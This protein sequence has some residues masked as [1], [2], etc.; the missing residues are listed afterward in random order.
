MIDKRTIFEIQQLNE[1]GKSQREIAQILSLSRMTVK[2]YILDSDLPSQSRKKRQ[3]KLEPYY[4]KINQF[5]QDDPKVSSTVIFQH[6]KELGYEGKLTILTDYIREKRGQ[7]K[8]KQAFI[9]F[10]S[11][12][13][14]QFQIDWGEFGSLSYGNTKRKLYAMLVTECHSRMLYV[15]FTHSQ[16]QSA[17]H[18]CLWHAFNYFGGTTRQII[19]DNMLT[20]VIERS[21]KIIRYNDAFLEFLR[22]FKISPAACTPRAPYEKGKVERSVG[23]VKRNFWPLR[24]FTDLAD[25]QTQALEWLEKIANVRTHQ[26]TGEVPLNR[27]QK[28]KLRPLPEVDFD[29]RETRDLLVH[30]DFS[31][32]FDCNTYTVHPW[33]IGKHIILKASQKDLEVYY[34]EKLVVHHTRCWDRKKRIEHP[35]HQEQVKKLRKKLWE[36]KEISIFASF[37]P[38]CRDFLN[39]LGQ[40]RQPI[41]KNV[42][43]LLRLKDEYGLNSLLFAIDKALKHKA[44]GA[45]YIENILH[46]EMTPIKNHPP[47]KLKDEALNQ[48][49]LIEP[50]LAE[51]DAEII[52]RSHI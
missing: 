14:E 9:R 41:K 16:N 11:E 8:P 10:E 29:F 18:Q 44:Y 7:I 40:A 46:Q 28:E 12:P 51:Y 42:I 39:A 50:L 31:I 4:E 49:R 6:L 15:E 25:A 45:D 26:T 34:K 13:G 21:G 36:S 27:F 23:Y 48:I 20:A 22:P 24:K 43:R 35:H 2:K 52:K 38:S 37:D 3:S 17:L 5:L 47:V 32:H 19:F 33:L 30:K 1:E